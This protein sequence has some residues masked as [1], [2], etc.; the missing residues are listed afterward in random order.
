MAHTQT[1]A[2]CEL[3]LTPPH[4][5][6]DKKEEATV[7]LRRLSPLSLSD[8]MQNPLERANVRM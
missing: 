2:L 6:T 8:T 3:I 7:C 5:T 1:A 4:T